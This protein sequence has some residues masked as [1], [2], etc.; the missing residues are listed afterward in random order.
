MKYKYKKW[1]LGKSLK[2]PKEIKQDVYDCYL[3]LED[4]I[5]YNLEDKIP[6]TCLKQYPDR[7]IVEKFGIEKAKTLDLELINK[8]LY[9]D[10]FFNKPDFHSVEEALL[11]I[12]PTVDDLNKALYEKIINYISPQKY[13]QKMKEK[14]PNRFID[15]SQIDNENQK[16][17]ASRFNKGNIKIADIIANWDLLKDKDLSYY[18]NNDIRNEY[19]INDS[20][21]KKCMNTYGNLIKL[22]EKYNIYTFMNKIITIENKREVEEYLKSTVDSILSTSKAD[23]IFSKDYFTDE[24]YKELFKYTSLKDYLKKKAGQYSGEYYV[25]ELF[26]ELDDLPQDYIFNTPIPFRYLKHSDILKFIGTY[27]LKNIVDFDND[28]GRFFTNNDC[29]M[30]CGMTSLYLYYPPSEFFTRNNYDENGNYVDRP[31]TKEEFY[32]ALR[33]MIINGPTRKEYVNKASNYKFITGEFR[34]KN[35]D[36]FINDNAP[37]ELKNAFYTKSITP[38]LIEEHPEYI[39]YLQGK[40]ISACFKTR[41]IRV[42]YET[43]T[44]Y[45][46][47]GL[48]NFIGKKTDFN[49]LINFIIQYND[50]LNIF[51]DENNSSKYI[52]LLDFEEDDSLSFEEV[53]KRL[54][55]ILK[56]AIIID[57]V[58]YP[59]NIIN[60]LRIYFP[61]IVLNDN[62]PKELK[63]TFYNR[64]NISSIILT[65]PEYKEYFKDIDLEVIYK[66][67]PIRVFDDKYSYKEI[68]FIKVLEQKFG[69]EDALDIMVQYGNYI[70][71][72]YS[73]NKLEKF[74]F[75]SS[76]S[77]EELLNQ[78]DFVVLDAIVESKI[79][80]D[81]KMPRHF[82]ENNPTLFLGKNVDKEIRDKFY[83]RELTLK[84]FENYPNLI[85]AFDNTNIVCG[86]N[87]ELSWMIPLFEN[88]DNYK[89]AN[90]KR[91]KVVSEYLKINDENFK[92]TFKKY[93]QKNINNIEIEKIESISRVLSRLSLSNSSEMY[94]LR[95]ELATRL[96]NTDNPIDNLNKIEAVFLKNNL[97][98]VGKAYSC[99]EILHPDFKGFNFGNSM[100]SPILKSKSNMGRKV[101]VFSDL[102]KASFG[103]NNRSVNSYIRNIRIGSELYNEIKN[104]KIKYDELNESQ[105][106]EL[107][108]FSNHLATLYHNTLKGKKDEKVFYP[109]GDVVNNILELS[110]LL[111][112]NGNSLDY[113]L[114]NRVISMFCHF[115]GIDT[116]EEAEYYIK[117]KIDNANTR[118]RQAASSDMVIETGDFI[119][120]I[121]DIKYLKNILQNGSVSKEYLG[122]NADSDNTPL[123]TDVS[124]ITYDG[125]INE[126]IKRNV[127]SGYG[128]IWLVLKNDDRFITTRNSDLETTKD[129]DLSKLE[130]FY[131]GVL[132]NSH[133]GIRTGFASSE[134]NYIVAE[135]YDYRIGLEIAMNGF[136]IPVANKEG[137]IVFTPND[138]DNLRRKMSGLS[139]YGEN[140]YLFSDNLITEE[141]EYLASKIEESNNE[142]RIKRDKINRVITKS[143]EELGLN[144][145]TIIDGDLTEGFVEL[146]DTGSTGRGTNKPGDGDFDFMMR[147]DN[148]I[149]QNPTK[150]S[151]LKNA[152]LKNLGKENTSEMTGNGDFRLK[153]VKLDTETIVD[154]DITF[155]GKTDKISYSTD[156][157][158]QERLSNIYNQN[159]EQ[160]KYV[161]ANILLAKQVL[162]EA[163]VYKPNRG[164][165]P[166]GGLGGV[167]IENWILQNG[168]S[169]IDAATDF[170]NCAE[171]KSFDEF[172]NTYYIWDFGENHMAE[173]RGQYTHDN[174]VTNN[175][176][177]SGYNK[178]VHVLR[179]YLNNYINTQNNSINK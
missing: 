11:Q 36:L 66:Y 167:G 114:A 119:K 47:E 7:E 60:E 68:N 88:E 101:V 92:N 126:K 174:F 31:Y 125:T 44:Y 95:N 111:S 117:T 179:E 37:D 166:Q 147:L 94:S 89:L 100:I 55:T 34:E 30:L 5:K 102:I 105:K 148:K 97:P 142:V 120:G 90:A 130:V 172:K 2:V 61:D 18:L 33:N 48:Y 151:E 24:E 58:Q 4:F 45:K 110:Q 80:Y 67:M 8:G 41:N 62:A 158:L 129:S 149:L 131:T 10:A 168:G 14:F 163:E 169:F 51:Y 170:L 6:I 1:Q 113:N 20:Q 150:L 64:K 46:E 78:I 155:T 138:Y 23:G 87:E 76:F 77:K 75:E 3:S 154:I 121:N 40:N 9:S 162:K 124:M 69:K 140:N 178:M 28:N 146:I 83:N 175:M 135:N 79:K 59:L 157:C 173:R 118:N 39:P 72:I 65:N 70:E 74:R 43:T 164:E 29:N 156:M 116:L 26:K 160:Y 137:K 109:T 134:I 122:S 86:F 56:R 112:P 176:S 57:G 42:K 128:K 25:D 153:G 63:D 16:E 54:L 107:L 73:I 53:K 115:A 144:L 141:T 99:F 81:D 143:L 103:S 133:Y 139:Y 136:Y 171:G 98:T 27:G 17:I 123:D 165:V 35:Q 159:P 12:E 127:A 19:E 38:S 32:L 96:L 104:G 13:S 85:D 71:K 49:N 84:D 145:K 52:Y 91:L 82:K 106:Q 161:I 132:G 21:L 108:T 50:V 22:L 93:I 177:E 152:L 15:V